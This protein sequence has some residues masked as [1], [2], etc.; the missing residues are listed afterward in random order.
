VS[1]GLHWLFSFYPFIFL[2]VAAIFSQQQLRRS[3]YFILPFTLLHIALFAFLMVVSPGIFK[4]NENNYKDVVYG[5][6]GKEIVQKLRAYQPEFILATDSYTESALLSYAAREHIIVLGVGSHHARQD[7]MIT[8][9]RKLDSKNI[10]MLSYS[11]QIE[12][13]R[14]YFESTESKPLPIAE[15][16][17]HML[18]G[19]GFRYQVYR[20][21]VLEEILQRY[22]KIP[23]FL[24]VGQCNMYDWYGKP[25]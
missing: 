22:Y 11:P 19:R 9:L 12:K 25:E 8:D 20:E 3:F 1:I 14:K 2:G 13:Y 17:Y 23:D 18:L 7:D 24:P 16:T 6:Y 10:L 21:T 5:M 4:S 15:T